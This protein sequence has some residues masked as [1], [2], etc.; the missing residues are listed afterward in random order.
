MASRLAGS[1]DVAAEDA[2]FAGGGTDVGEGSVESGNIA[3]FDID[4]KL[5]LPGAA[6][7]GTALDL[8][9]IYTVLRE[10]LQRSK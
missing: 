1:G 5:I 7:N 9:E 10:R 4:E 8:E 3:G 6:V 2:E